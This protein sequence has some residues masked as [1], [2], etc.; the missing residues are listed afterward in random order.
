MSALHEIALFDQGGHLIS[1]SYEHSIDEAKGRLLSLAKIDFAATH[2]LEEEDISATLT[3]DGDG[4]YTLE[5][6]I[7]GD[8]DRLIY[9]ADGLTFHDLGPIDEQATS[10]GRVVEMYGRMIE[11]LAYYFRAEYLEG[12]LEF[13]HEKAVEIAKREMWEYCCKECG[14]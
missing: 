14:L 10:Q 3:P 9:T 8:D 4:T 2:G 1:S 7:D 11:N 12:V 5:Y 6:H 13:P